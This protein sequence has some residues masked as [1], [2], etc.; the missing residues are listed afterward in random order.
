MDYWIDIVKILGTIS[1]TGGLVIWFI[2]RSANRSD[3]DH[4]III[5]IDERVVNL[6]KDLNAAHEK[7]RRLEHE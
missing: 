2:R 6:R 5:R 3:A 1:G 7:I 4:D